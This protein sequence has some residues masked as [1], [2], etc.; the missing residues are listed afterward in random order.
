MGF[1]L[2]LFSLYVLGWIRAETAA[3]CYL[4][5]YVTVVLVSIGTVLWGDRREKS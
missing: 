1:P 5:G 4:V 2:V 3:L